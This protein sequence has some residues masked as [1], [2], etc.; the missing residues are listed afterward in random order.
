M[1]ATALLFPG[2]GAQSVGM[3]AALAAAFPAARDLF[4]RAGAVLGYDLL[5]L[6]AAG[7]EDQL[8]ESHYAQPAIFVTSLAALAALRIRQ[9][10]AQFAMAA[11]LSSGEWTALHAAGGLAFEDTLRILEARGRF[12]QD[13]CRQQPGGMLSVIGLGGDGLA[14]VCRQSGAEIANLNSPGQTVLSGTLE[15]IAA[16][17]RLA[18]GAGARK[19]IRLNVAGAFHSSLM[20]PAAAQLAEFLAPIPFAAPAFPVVANVTAR[21]HT[22][23]EEIKRLMV[24][25]VTSSVRW[26]ESIQWLHSQGVARMVECGPGKVLTGLVKRID[27]QAVLH[28]IQD[29]NDVERT[30]LEG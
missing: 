9:P 22:T 25:Q 2:Q 13:A 21:P 17:E 19:T 6:C 3:G 29:A 24:A 30:V 10:A 14:D 5:Q 8:V 1:I 7:P 11:G 27:K 12:M 28:N 15:A 20:A 26:V 16:A 18:P 4:A 23:P